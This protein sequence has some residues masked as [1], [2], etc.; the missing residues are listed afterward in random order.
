MLSTYKAHN[1]NV[2]AVVFANDGLSFA[3]CSKEIKIWED[4]NCFVFEK[5]E[6]NDSEEFRKKK[7][8][9]DFPVDLYELSK[10]SQEHGRKGSQSKLYMRY[11]QSSNSLEDLNEKF[12]CNLIINSYETPLSCKDLKIVEPKHFD[13]KNG[14]VLIQRGAFELVKKS[15]D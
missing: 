4:S 11:H 6:S 14:Q 5:S 2:N 15:S 7:S 10:S 1:G 3:S 8:T 13:S 9:G 12:I